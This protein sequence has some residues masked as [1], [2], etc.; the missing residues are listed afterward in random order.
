MTGLDRLNDKLAKLK[1]ADDAAE[2]TVAGG[3][4]GILAALL[5]EIEET[6]L[7]REMVLTNERGEEFRLLVSGRRLIRAGAPAA[8][9]EDDDD[10]A[11]RIVAAFNGPLR[12]FLDG[13]REISIAAGRPR[14]RIDPT[15]MG[16][17]AEI[18]ARSVTPARM[19]DPVADP[20]GACLDR[21]A[22][23]L[24]LEGG[25]VTATLGDPS[26]AARLE[27][28]G[29]ALLPAMAE[30]A[31]PAESAPVCTVLEGSAEGGMILAHVAFRNVAALILAP[32]SARDEMLAICRGLRPL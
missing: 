9:P 4:D 14:E 32:A 6:I 16:C 30:T 15:E 11:G 7:P 26:L 22:A 18:L 19:P 31:G 24:R 12:A 13:A 28:L 23:G 25:A 8:A 1:G 27:R 29:P 17:S 2:Q 5:S 10:P 20:V 21:A 3:T